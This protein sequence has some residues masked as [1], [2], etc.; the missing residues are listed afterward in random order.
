[1]ISTIR[2]ISTLE[3]ATSFNSF[4]GFQYR[5]S[6]ERY[7]MFCAIFNARNDPCMTF[8]T[9]NTTYNYNSHSIFRIVLLFQRFNPHGEYDF[10]YRRFE[11][12]KPKRPENSPSTFPNSYLKFRP[13]S[14]LCNIPR[15]RTSKC[16]CF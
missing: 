14:I 3:C 16:L 2:S 7:L 4:P 6:P 12:L 11:C 5:F 1:M 13:Q 8:K 10:I 9:S 15:R